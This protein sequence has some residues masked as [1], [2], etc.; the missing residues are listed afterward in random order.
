M[1]VAYPSLVLYVYCTL[2]RRL[3]ASRRPPGGPMPIVD[4]HRYCTYIVVYYVRCWPISPPTGGPMPVEYIYH[5]LL[6]CITY[7]AGL[8]PP[9]GVPMPVVPS[10]VLYI[11]CAILRRPLA[12]RRLPGGPMPVVDHHRYCTYIAL[13]YVRRWPLTADRQADACST[14]TGT[15]HTTRGRCQQGGWCTMV[16]RWPTL[17]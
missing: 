5:Y 6:Y 1:P 7:A 13:Y 9:T 10:T 14:I 11:Y 4:H 16:H 15:V 12:F 8:L 2:L 3:L 17:A